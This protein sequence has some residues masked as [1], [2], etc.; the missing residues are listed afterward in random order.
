MANVVKLKRSAVSGKNPTTSDLQLG[1]VALNTTDGNLFFKRDS[2][3]LESIITVVN[4][5]LS[6]TLINK[7][8]GN[9]VTITDGS[10]ILATDQENLDLSS[11]AGILD[12]QN[13]D[14]T[15]TQILTST[16]TGVRWVD[17][18]A[19]ELSGLGD[20]SLSG[21]ETNQILK[22]N[23]TLWVNADENAVVS[24]AI[25]AA[26]A[27]SDLG[28][29]TDPNITITEDLEPRDWHSD[30]GLGDTD[31]YY[32]M[33]SIAIDGVVGLRNVDQSL[34]SDYISYSIIFGF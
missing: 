31:T 22:Y 20:V 14:G 5:G 8:F 32:N 9:D 13:S 29:V 34:K 27:L 15:P 11:G 1:E 12:D 18:T 16:G 28:Y 17:N 25:F 21:L 10:L 23:G 7:S 2:N 26:N 3:G 30:N 19:G 4:T 24:S 6:Q 33:G